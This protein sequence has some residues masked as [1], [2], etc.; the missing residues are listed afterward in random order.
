MGAQD[1]D[2]IAWDCEDDDDGMGLGL[3]ENGL[4]FGADEDDDGGGGGVRD[5]RRMGRAG[6]CGKATSCSKLHMR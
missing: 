4:G 6:A 1:I 5:A 2:V 3:D